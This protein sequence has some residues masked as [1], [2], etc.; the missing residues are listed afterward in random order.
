MNEAAVQAKAAVPLVKLDGAALQSQVSKLL[1]DI[2]AMM[3]HPVRLDFQDAP[4]GALAVALHF[5][6]EPPQGVANGKR[7]QLVDSLQFL[8]NKA[9]N[10]PNVERRWVNLGVGGFPEPKTVKPP[11]PSAPKAPA[12]PAPVK[13]HP[14]PKASAPNGHAAK[15]NGKPAPA[16]KPQHPK[17]PDERTLTPAADKALTALATALASKAAAKGRTYAVMLASPDDRARLLHAADGAKGVKVRAEGEGYF[18][19]VTFVPDA[20]QP[21]PRKAAFPLD[22]DD[23]DEG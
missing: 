20:P 10:R 4:D 5:D 22:L 2:L 6:G 23:E 21:M 8:L 18:R 14:G 1:T 11:Q 7:S 16:A 9:V 12:A 15:P 19:R 17:E 13:G 3:E